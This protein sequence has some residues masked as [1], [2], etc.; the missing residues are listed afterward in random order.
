LC[1]DKKICRKPEKYDDRR[2]DQTICNSSDDRIQ[3][4]NRELLY[5]F[6]EFINRQE[7]S[8][9][10]QRALFFS[11]ILKYRLS[12]N[13][14]VFS[15]VAILAKILFLLTMNRLQ[16]FGY[17]SI[18]PYVFFALVGVASFVI[19]QLKIRNEVINWVT[20]PQLDRIIYDEH[21]DLNDFLKNR[22]H[23]KG[24][25]SGKAHLKV[26]TKVCNNTTPSSSNQINFAPSDFIMYVNGNNVSIATFHGLE[27]GMD[28][29]LSPGRYS[30][31]ESKP[32]C[33]PYYNV[34]YS[35]D[36]VGRINEN[37]RRNV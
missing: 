22:F 17:Y 10:I 19:S 7:N 34:E 35:P 25:V 31:T 4:E 16:Y 8:W 29:E 12:M 20:R 11:Y 9:T 23:P 24:N 30:V 2:K 26:I 3:K 18:I 36:C 27:S 13:L 14:I 5:I 6:Y 15:L 28:I 32:H 37:E 1:S 33:P 21:D